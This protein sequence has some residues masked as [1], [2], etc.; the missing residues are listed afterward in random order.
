MKKLWVPAMNNHGRLGRWS[1][2]EIRDIYDAEKAL[3][4]SIAEFKSRRVA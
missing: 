2:L 3:R 4:M 1:F